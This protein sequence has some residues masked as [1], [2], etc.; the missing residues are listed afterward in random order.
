M[1]E[2]TNEDPTSQPADALLN[3][4]RS[5]NRIILLT[6]KLLTLFCMTF[7]VFAYRQGFH[8]HS[9]AVLSFTVLMGLSSYLF[10]R[11]PESRASRRF[12][13]LTCS[14]LAMYIYYTGGTFGVGIAWTVMVPIFGFFVLGERDGL[15]FT[16]LFLLIAF[17]LFALHRIFPHSVHLPYS[18][19]AAIT[20]LCIYIFATLVLFSYE[21]SQAKDKLLLSKQ[22]AYSS[23]M[24]EKALRASAARS[25][26][27]A[28]VSHEM[29]TPLNSIVGFAE[30][31]LERN[32]DPD[33]RRMLETVE[34]QSETLLK[35]IDDVLDESKMGAG[36]LELAPHPFDLMAMLDDVHSMGLVRAAERGISLTIDCPSNVPR[37]LFGDGLR[38]KQVLVNLVGN[39]I[40]FTHQGS[41]T[42]RARSQGP[43]EGRIRLRLDVIDTG[44][45]I[46]KDKQEKI[47][48]QFA[49]ADGSTTRCYGGTGLGTTISRNLVRLMGGE[50]CLES[51]SGQGSTF[52]FEIELPTSS[53]AEVRALESYETHSDTLPLQAARVLVAEDYEP[54][55][56]VVRA[57][58]ES[59]G[60]HVQIVENGL[61]ALDAF[62]REKFDIILLDVQMPIMDGF[63]AARRMRQMECERRVEHP[64][65][66]P[67][68][69]II[70]L[71]ANVDSVS[72][73]RAIESGMNDILTKPIRRRK[74]LQMVQ[75]HVRRSAPPSASHSLNVSPLQASS[76]PPIDLPRLLEDFDGHLAP[77]LGLL[78][79]FRSQL[80]SLTLEMRE[81]LNQNELEKVR[82]SAHKSKGAAANY[83]ADALARI[84]AQLE[85]A[86]SLGD[87]STCLILLNKWEMEK[88]RLADFLHQPPSVSTSFPPPSVS[89]GKS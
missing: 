11:N 67:P 8:L 33:T 37:W 21:T 43:Q 16:V 25:E 31:L 55:Q 71:T 84:S 86:A 79:K 63:E 50:L 2:L 27:I 12:V 68:T 51:E 85:Q 1:S 39:A 10:Q 46:P 59:A 74:L 30:I 57:H 40:K 75:H 60:H 49:Q 34:H 13:I 14:C 56:Q 88:Q 89:R 15:T 20:S 73:T 28:N 5:K 48:E 23:H 42:L 87:G 61:S 52:F 82:S 58:L 3:S 26:F 66:G 62:S 29:R 38:L 83:A 6:S 54:N 35:L 44:I 19:G 69:P 45:G 41:V 17:I 77:T 78:H 65:A 70:A 4:Q 76:T 32:S 80:D 22:L 64:D 53:E 81:A 7:S 47:F 72:R 24:A 18:F 36:R 9:L